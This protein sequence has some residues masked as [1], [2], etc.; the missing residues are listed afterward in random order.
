MSRF[1]AIDERFGFSEL[2]EVSDPDFGI[3]KSSRAFTE[4]GGV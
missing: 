1:E 2:S 4:S 3:G